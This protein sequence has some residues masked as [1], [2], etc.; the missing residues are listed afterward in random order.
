MK[1]KIEK[2]FIPIQ[3]II[4]YF[5]N[6]LFSINSKIQYSFV[7]GVDEIANCI[8]FLKKSFQDES[9]SVNLKDHKFYR[10]NKYDY[11]I[12]IKNK[13]L[14][15]FTRILYGPYLLAKLSNQADVFI[16]FWYTG[17]CVDR[18]IDYKFL[19]YKKKKVVCIFVGDDIRSRKLLKERLIKEDI[20][21]YVFYDNYD[22]TKNEIRVKKVAF[23]SDTYANLAF[24]VKK[25]QA[26]YL[27]H[28]INKFMYMIDD[29]LLE[30]CKFDLNNKRIK[31]VHAPSNPILKGTPLVKAAIKKL[32]LEGYEFEY[33]ELINKTNMEVLSLLSD[34]HIVLN[35][36][37]ADM[38]GIFGIEAMAKKNAVL[39]SADYENLPTKGETPWLRTK[40]WEVY[41]NLKYLLDNPLEI[42]KYANDGYH[43]IKNNYTEEKVREF[44]INTFYD[45]KI[46]DDKRIF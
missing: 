11:S 4:L 24:S 30:N 14:E 46:I 3:V 19:K 21:S 20:D 31:I 35:Q 7:I 26:S 38:P 1:S 16:Y 28:Y 22:V 42:E 17:F 43:F 34:S 44:Y 32:E 45:H 9:I 13:Y 33:I 5:F 25:S 40:Y 6:F 39:M 27:E 15:F 29:K 10:S 23:L 2:L 8:Y 12:N 41:D 18:E 37:Y 36:F